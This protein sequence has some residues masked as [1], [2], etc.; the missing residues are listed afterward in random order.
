VQVRNC[1]LMNPGYSNPEHFYT[2]M[3]HTTK[4]LARRPEG[5]IYLRQ[6]PRSCS[7]GLGGSGPPARG[8]GKDGFSGG[9]QSGSH[10]SRLFH[11][12][13][14]ATSQMSRSSSIASRCPGFAESGKHRHRDF[15]LPGTLRRGR[16]SSRHRVKPAPA[17]VVPPS[18]KPRDPSC[19]ASRPPEPVGNRRRAPC[20]NPRHARVVE[21]GVRQKPHFHPE[22]EVCISPR[23]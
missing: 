19:L 16:A 15:P 8:L 20:A 13:A 3:F 11:S 22:R 14:S 6:T 5:S 12:N 1:L 2:E 18:P 23:A 9:S 17:S 7:W 4:L 21:I 10:S